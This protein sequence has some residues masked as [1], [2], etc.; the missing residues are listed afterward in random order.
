MIVVC[1]APL[2]Y[3]M[4]ENAVVDPVPPVLVDGEPHSESYGSDEGEMI[5]WFVPFS[6]IV[7]VRQWSGL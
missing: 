1:N 7:Q 3:V 6:C 4:C 2:A 5:K